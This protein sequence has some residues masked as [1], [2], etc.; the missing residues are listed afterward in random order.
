MHWHWF[1][2]QIF[3]SWVVFASFLVAKRAGSPLVAVLVVAFVSYL[4]Y[5]SLPGSFGAV[6][7]GL[8]AYP[9][10]TFAAKRQLFP[11][12]VCVDGS[13]LLIGTYSVAMLQLITIAVSDIEQA[14][15]LFRHNAHYWATILSLHFG[16]C[17][18]GW[19]IT[20]WVTTK[21]IPMVL[22][23]ALL[24]V[25][26]NAF[27]TLPCVVVVLIGY[28]AGIRSRIK[29]SDRRI[30]GPLFLIN[31][32]GIG[33]CYAFITFFTIRGIGSFFRQDDAVVNIS[34]LLAPLLFSQGLLAVALVAKDSHE[35]ET[36]T[37]A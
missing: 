17:L 23:V 25:L 30:V 29:I 28:F 24:A 2:G 34:T 36:A 3:A 27:V 13:A 22:F 14:S 15:F 9:V 18:V 10:V 37:H 35:S 31:G 12:P 32:V 8:L 19:R 1:V 7:S 4:L 5:Y 33:F 11:D 21:W 26:V 16:V 20:R 6:V